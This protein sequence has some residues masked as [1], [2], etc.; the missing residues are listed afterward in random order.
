MSRYDL[1]GWNVEGLRFTF[2]HLENASLS[3]DGLWKKLTKQQN[4]SVL[5]P[6]AA[7][8]HMAFGPSADGSKNVAVQFALPTRID[9]A[10]QPSSPSVEG[11]LSIGSYD[12]SIADLRAMLQC[13]N[14][15]LSSGALRYA[16][17]IVFSRKEADN[18]AASKALSTLINYEI[19]DGSQDFNFQIN[20]PIWA[21][22]SGQINR[23]L[24]CAIGQIQNIAFD[25]SGPASIVN[26]L[27]AQVEWDI[28]SDAMNKNP[29]HNPLR[30]IDCIFEQLD[31]CIRGGF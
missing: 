17:G 14:D 31:E 6:P 5:H 24:R 3:P 26:E 29:I 27:V 23:I 16:V 8:V 18:C 13:I 9:I 7:P 30:L 10:I 15:E 22:D 21:D 1:S 4:P 28:N 11:L 12:Q 19:P 25:T 2:F 20:K